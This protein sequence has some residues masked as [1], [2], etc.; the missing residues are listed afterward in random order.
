MT[1]IDYGHG[2]TNIDT[3]TGIRYGVISQ[4][5]IAP[6]ASEDISSGGENLTYAAAVREAK[7]T[8]ARALRGPLDEFGV[9]PYVS[10]YAPTDR[11][12]TEQNKT[13]DSIVESVWDDIEQDFNDQYQP[14]S[15]TY[16]YESDGYVLETTDLGV[17]VIKSPFFTF[18]TFCSPCCPGAGD[19]DS[20]NADGVKTYCLGA[21]WFENDN[22]PYPVFSVASGEQK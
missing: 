4:H 14:D 1:G 6:E 10:K 11:Q 9:L 12:K 21:E 8:I 17:Y 22:A 2:I 18:C 19:L 15:E 7:E 3:A 16:R 20:P 13:L 5:S